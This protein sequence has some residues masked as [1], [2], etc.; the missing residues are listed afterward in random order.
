MADPGKEVVKVAAG[1]LPLERAGDRAVTVLEEEQA[2][3][4]LFQT[5]EVVGS[6]GF[7]LKHREVDL[8]LIEPTAMDRGMN[9]EEIG[10]SG[11]ESALA[12]V[13]SVR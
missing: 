1:K 3:L 8:D 12:G 10:P 6:Q 13:S 9:D 2:L 5:G 11:L 7:S 4:E